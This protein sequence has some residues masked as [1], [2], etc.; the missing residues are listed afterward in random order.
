MPNQDDYPKRCPLCGGQIGK[1]MTLEEKIRNSS[2][3]T[4]KEK[5]RLIILLKKDDEEYKRK[6][7]EFEQMKQRINSEIEK[8]RKG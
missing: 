7:S 4:I 6:L 8:G 1:P 2:D 3:F 5:M